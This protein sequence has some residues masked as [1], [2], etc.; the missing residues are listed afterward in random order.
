M[1][2]IVIVLLVALMLEAVGVVFL[3]KGIVEIGDQSRLPLQQSI[4]FMAPRLGF[5]PRTLCPQPQP[6]PART[7]LRFA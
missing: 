7:G 5:W 6:V 4:H 1:Y 3:K 2:K